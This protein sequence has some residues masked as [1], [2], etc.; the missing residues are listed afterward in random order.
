MQKTTKSRLARGLFL[1]RDIARLRE[2]LTQIQPLLSRQNRI[3][4]T[5]LTEFD[6]ATERVISDVFG[7]ASDFSEAYEYAKLGEA[8]SLVNLPEEAQEHGA[9][10][11]ERES[12]QQRKGVLDSCITQLEEL[13]TVKMVSNPRVGDYISTDLRSISMD[14]TLQEAARL[15][16]KWNVGS[17]LVLNGSHYVGV[18]TDTDLSRKAMADGLDAAG[19]AVAACMTKPLIS[20]DHGESMTSA[21]ALMRAHGIRHVAVTKDG[22]V[23]GVLSISDI[24]RYYSDTV[25]ALRHLAGLTDNGSATV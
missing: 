13:R 16:Q 17:L 10:D 8:A 7:E 11:V 2:Q 22:M 9:Q 19:T 6:A 14:A 15:L 1:E 4:A 20:I 5:A 23:I 12:L 21:V 18:I 25:P 3:S 24:V